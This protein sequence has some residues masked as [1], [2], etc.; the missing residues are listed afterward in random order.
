M[1]APKVTNLGY[2]QFE[3]AVITVTDAPIQTNIP[4]FPFGKIF[5]PLVTK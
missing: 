5:L 4:L 2:R 1:A 3:S